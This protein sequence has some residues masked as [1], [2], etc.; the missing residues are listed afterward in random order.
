MAFQLLSTTRSLVF[1][2]VVSKSKAQLGQ[3]GGQHCALPFQGLHQ[4]TSL[5]FFFLLW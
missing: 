3:G 4:D 2:W 5:R 1:W